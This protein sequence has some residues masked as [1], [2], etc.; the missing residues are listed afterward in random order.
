MRF[1][2]WRTDLEAVYADLDV[3]VCC[4]INE[5]TPVS[6]IEAGAAGVPVV[7][8]DVGGV[9]DVVVDGETGFV[10]PPGDVN[11]LG[12]ALL[13]ILDDRRLAEELSQ[14]A[15]RWV[16][17]RYSSDRLVADIRILYLSLLSRQPAAGGLA[18]SAPR[19]P[20]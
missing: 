11:G 12:E 13:R 19:I 7:A 17:D 6:L 15:R 20:L 16:R 9:R 2:G 10:V 8:T 5:G 14:A 4:S 1:T 3:A 18:A